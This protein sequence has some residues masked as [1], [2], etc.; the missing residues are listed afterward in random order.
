MNKQILTFDPVP[1][2]G[3]SKKVVQSIL[4]ITPKNVAVFVVSNDKLS[5][6]EAN[7]TLLPLYN[8]TWLERQT[9]G[10]GYFVKHFLYSLIVFYYVMRFGFFG[11]AIGIS[12]PTVDFALYL[13]KFFVFWEVIQLIQGNVPTTRFAGY[14]LNRATA[15]FYLTSTESSIESALKRVNKVE[16]LASNKYKCFVNSVDATSISKRQHNK[17]VGILWVSSLLPWKRL[18]VFEKAFEKIDLATD[19][20]K[21]SYFASACFIVPK[22]IDVLTLNKNIPNFS[23]YHD[24]KNLDEIRSLSSIFVST[25]MN[26]PF[27]LSILEAMVAGLAI[28]IPKDNAYWDQQLTHGI[29]CLKFDP[30]SV[31]SLH[32]TML[33]LI[34]DKQLRNEISYNGQVVAQHYTDFKCYSNILKS[35]IK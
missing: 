5:W 16:L 9:T 21:G 35:I 26:E 30:N 11:K 25:S 20:I 7:V 2:K 34:N 32:L 10:I 1:Y 19:K 23:Y 12:G 4:S 17:S 6:T 28:I 13:V 18:D 22:A 27:G 33:T 8:S 3:G 15:V 24:P 31:E 29:H 14:G